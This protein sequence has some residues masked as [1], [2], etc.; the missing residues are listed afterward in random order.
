[1]PPKSTWKE[2][3][4]VLWRQALIANPCPDFNAE[5]LQTADAGARR[6]LVL[7]LIAAA[8]RG[9]SELGCDVWKGEG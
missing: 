8:H 2:E 5:F 7:R 4:R 3:V 6:H 9:L 1:M